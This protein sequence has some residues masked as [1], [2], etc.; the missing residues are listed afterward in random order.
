MARQPSTFV[1]S[2][3]PFDEDEALDED[4]LRGHYR[5]MAAAGIGVY[6]VGGGSGEAYTLEPGEPRR[7][8]EIAAEEL[9]GKV[10]V[11]AM[12]VE[13]RAAK[14]MVAF[15]KLVK[16]A[17]LDAM[18]VY[19]LD[20]GHGASPD[21]EELETY[22]VDVLDEVDIPCVISTH[23]S[24][25]YMIPIDVLERLV[26]R[27]DQI[28]GINCTAHDVTYLVRLLDAIDERIEV[29][30][31]GPMQALTAL[32]LG[33]S[34]YLSSEAN[35]APRLAMQI[36]D[37]WKAGDF[38]GTNE[39]FARFLR[40]FT[41]VIGIGG[42]RGTKACLSMLG[43]P[44]GSVRKP[45]LRVLDDATTAMLRRGIEELGIAESELGS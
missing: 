14:Q 7:V 40:L 31:G 18:Q 8:L 20:I 27:Y 36:I 38:A 12:G 16:E 22:F 21:P 24:V 9:K 30:V 44:G 23:Y 28:I 45:R 2:L 41:M 25:G 37:R 43:L 10:P 34:G 32:A 5:R 15:S 39:A 35:L 6:V 3:T 29:H 13:P 1:I 42:M 19:S 26:A 11:R 4:A 33:A 17:G